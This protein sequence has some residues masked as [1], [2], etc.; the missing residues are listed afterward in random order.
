MGAGELNANRKVSGSRLFSYVCRYL[1]RLV[2]FWSC[3]VHR[4]RRAPKYNAGAFI[5]VSNHISHFDPPMLAS[6]FPRYIDWMAMD[7]LY[8]NRWTASLMNLLCAFPVKRSR[9]DLGSIRAA[10]DR[11]K[12]GRVVG[13]FPEGGIRAGASSLLEGAPIWTGFAG[14]SLLSGKPVIPCVIIGT[15]RLYRPANWCP[16]RRVQVW[17]A[18]GEPCYPRTDL[19][20]EPARALLVQEVERLLLKLKAE[21]VEHFALEPADLPQTPQYRKR[22][23]FVPPQQKGRAVVQA[24]K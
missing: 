23:L 24:K 17:M 19:P 10:L 11:L 21:L 8:S 4:L 3:R 14:L 22:E 7:E 1:V 5:V 12:L 20:R 2:F 13:I 6:W 15:D 16:F 9:R 18:F